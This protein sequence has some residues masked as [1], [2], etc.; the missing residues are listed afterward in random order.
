MA[1]LDREHGKQSTFGSLFHLIF[2]LE[3]PIG[4][5]SYYPGHKA[6]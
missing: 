1:V 5:G 6:K 4:S 3:S 2:D